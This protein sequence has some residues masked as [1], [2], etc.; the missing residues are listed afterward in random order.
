MKKFIIG[1]FLFSSLSVF[2]AD[3]NSGDE[4]VIGV[5][6]ERIQRGLRTGDF[7]C[8]GTCIEFSIDWEYIKKVL[9]STSTPVD[10]KED[11]ANCISEYNITKDALIEIDQM[12][13]DGQITTE[14]KN[15]EIEREYLVLNIIHNGCKSKLGSEKADNLRS[16]ILK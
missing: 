12:A 11:I 16:S 7:S 5:D 8:K 2:A 9:F 10:D 3:I 14:E 4:A 6:S 13:I 1:I 15:Q